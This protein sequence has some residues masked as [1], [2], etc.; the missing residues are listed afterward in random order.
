L[1]K[2]RLNPWGLEA[3]G[4]TDGFISG[5]AALLFGERVFGSLVKIRSLLEQ[6]IVQP[7]VNLYAEGRRFPQDDSPI[8]LLQMS[9]EE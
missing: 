4:W 7:L 6:K 5:E 2:G 8:F 9:D 1:A 3:S